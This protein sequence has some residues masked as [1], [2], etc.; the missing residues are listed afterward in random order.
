MATLENI[1]K[2]AGVLV[3]IVIGLALLA[4]I[5]GDF[6]SGSGSLF[7]QSQ[8]ELAQI[9]GTSI[10][11]DLYQS[12]I[13]ESE[14][15][16]KLL[17]NQASIDEQTTLRIREQVWQDLVRT[18]VMTP[19]YSRLGIEIHPDEM[20]DM[21]QGKNIHPIISQQFADPKTGVLN[22]EY[23][24]A[25]LQNMNN[26]ANMKYYWLFLEKEIL[27]DR[28]FT[29]Y[30]NL[31]R[32][33]LYITNLQ[34]KKSIEDRSTKVDFN[35][36]VAKLSSVPDSLVKITDTDLKNYYAD[37]KSDFKQDESRDVE[38]VVFPV[39]P[40]KEDVIATEEYINKAKTELASAD[41]PKQYVVL[42]S[43]VQ[44]DLRYKNKEELP[45]EFQKWAF[46][47]KVGDVDGPYTDGNSYVIARLVDVKSMPDS[48][49][50]RHI[51]IQPKAQGDAAKAEAKATAD[52]L[53]AVIKRGNANWNLLAEK[54]ST[55]PG[56][57]DKGGDLGWFGNGVM[58]A[59]FDK[60]CFESKKGQIELVETQF[61]FHIIQVVDRSKESK[62]VQLAVMEREIV[63]S[64]QTIQ[65]VY[66]EAST[67]AG[68]NNTNELFNATVA[69]Q[70]MA[71]RSANNLLRNDRNIAGLDSPRELIRWAFKS[72]MGDVSTVFEF[73]DKYVVATVTAIREEG[74]APL[75]QVAQEVRLKVM[76]DKKI[77]IL[78]A[79]VAEA[80][81]GT[82]DLN[83][84][85][86]KLN[87]KVETVD[88]LSFSSYT[89]P[90]AGF[91]PVV[92]GTVGSLAENVVT[93]PIDGNNGVFAVSV[94]AVNTDE[95]TDLSAEK[96]RLANTYQSRAYY[97][98]YEA[99]KKNANI[100]DK[101]YNFY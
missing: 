6:V 28:S 8:M 43:D 7:N 14:A 12:K 67:F 35:Y 1:R 85:A 91:E 36:V 5:L 46:E 64:S 69:E 42:N 72:E 79:K 10:P 27:K 34:A 58:V 41:D 48:V 100:V 55:D 31:I 60:A 63:A 82:T 50:A 44:V 99:L 47:A 86:S 53:L 78:N 25:F 18:N 62:K 26:D 74:I 23:L 77:E 17:S 22:K 93:G 32:K 11:Y 80:M 2:R 83:A 90:N 30:T 92:V 84:I 101:R 40:S 29:K 51:L 68:Q 70:K 20:F 57:K 65:K 76:H 3:S 94:S 15:L 73:G 16:Q 49:N 54:Y 95:Q 38:Y 75:T 21:V 71:K 97:E 52:S 66:T 81:I 96:L 98:A 39:N 19:E 4:F 24:M 89:L 45:E 33:G 59:E 56:S 61:G 87:T 13:E 88:K 9:N 37:H